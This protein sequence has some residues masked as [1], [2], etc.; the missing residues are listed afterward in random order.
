MLPH[1]AVVV[2]TMVQTAPVDFSL[3]YMF[4]LVP[5]RSDGGWNGRLIAKGGKSS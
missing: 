4:T 1:V 5:L 2:D 3:A